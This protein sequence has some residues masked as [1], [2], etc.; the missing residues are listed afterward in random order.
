MSHGLKKFLTV[1]ISLIL[2]P[3][4]CHGQEL[5]HP[6]IP[7]Q[8][9]LIII[10]QQQDAIDAYID[11][12]G[13]IPGGVMSYTSIE[14]VDGLERPADHNGGIMNAQYYVNEYPH[15]ALQLALYMV[16]DL[17]DTIDGVY[18]VNIVKLAR[19][20][21]NTGCPIYLRIGYEFDL[22][23]N[24]YDPGKYQKAYRHIV[25]H[26]RAQGVDNVAF[27]W[28]SACMLEPKHNIMDWYPGDDYVDWFAVSIFNPMQIKV[29][30]EFFA[31]GR[32]HHKPLM[33]AESAP[34]GLVSTRAKMEWFKHYFDFID[35][36]N[37]KIV[38]YINSDWGSYP[39]FKSMGWGDSRIQEDPAI[40]DMWEKRMHHGYLQ[41]SVDLNRELTE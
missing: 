28:H 26:L 18:D 33:I 19:W 34:A 9:K 29:A 11:N 17:D 23:K 5:N 15:M 10:G 39:M 37:V 2:F 7:Q 41:Y 30:E 24:E 35:H 38:S 31:V 1:M 25:D 32:G 22:P 3:G 4:F 8:G 36:A 14:N 27:V 21:K 12:T 6:F 13:T 20:M 40:E 16:G